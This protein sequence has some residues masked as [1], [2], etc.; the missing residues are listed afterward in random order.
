ML[1]GY[2]G[3]TYRHRMAMEFAHQVETGLPSPIPLYDAMIDAIE[4]ASAGNKAAEG[5]H[6]STGGR[7]TN[8]LTRARGQ[9][10]GLPRSY[11]VPV[12]PAAAA[13]TLRTLHTHP[14]PAAARARRA[15]GG[16][17]RT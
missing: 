2:P 12:R 10:A 1:A 8:G 4:G 14:R 9:P 17:R 15:D 5:A 16:S 3:R 7:L 11:A 6:A 13:A